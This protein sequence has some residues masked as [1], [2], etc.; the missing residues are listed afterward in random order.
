MVVVRAT[1]RKLLLLGW[2]PREADL[3][4]NLSEFALRCS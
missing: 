4:V 3:G 2:T 1:R